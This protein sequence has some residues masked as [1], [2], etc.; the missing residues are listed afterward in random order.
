MYIYNTI[1][2][3]DCQ[4][5]DKSIIFKTSLNPQISLHI[6]ICSLDIYTFSFVN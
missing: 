3:F 1:I 6:V 5:C 4:W 2:F